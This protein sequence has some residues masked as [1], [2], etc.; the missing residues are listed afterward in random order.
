MITTPSRVFAPPKNLDN[1]TA[2]GI[3]CEIRPEE[4]VMRVD[5]NA[6]AHLNGCCRQLPY[7]TR[8]PADLLDVDGRG[9][10]AGVDGVRE[11]KRVT[12]DNRIVGFTVGV[13]ER[14]TRLTAV[15]AERCNTRLRTAKK[16]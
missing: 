5:R 9:G 12:G 8:A 4:I 3:P 6:D 2:S 7:R 1:L 13:V 15:T 10:L 14:R 16:G 11:I